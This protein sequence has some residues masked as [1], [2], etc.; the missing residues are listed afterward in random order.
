MLDLETEFFNLLETSESRWSTL[1]I[2][3]RTWF[4]I[5]VQHFAWQAQIVRL[6]AS[7][8]RIETLRRS[9]KEGDPDPGTVSDVE[10]LDHVETWRVWAAPGKRRAKFEVGSQPVDVVI[11]GS[12]FW[13]NGHGR[14]IT[15]GGNASHSHGQ[16]DGHNLIRTAE[17]ADLLHVVELSEGMR[18][19]RRTID[20]KVTIVD[21][22]HHGRGPG[23]H[24][25]TMGDPD[26]LALSVDRERGVVLTASSSLQGETYRIVEIIDVAFD[27][28]FEHEVFEIE[29]EY[30]AEWV[31][32]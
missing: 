24:G 27:P 2:D 5:N 10:P 28:D 25:L 23:V 14:S 29:P 16:G 11:E 9:P 12:T 18:L 20:A 8:A 1:F 7:G 17:Y 4:N 31:L 32:G 19:G 22:E 13:S 3:G 26:V 6:K 21:K 30:S 15:N